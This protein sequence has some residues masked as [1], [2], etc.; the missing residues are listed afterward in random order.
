MVVTT[1]SANTDSFIEKHQKEVYSYQVN[2][3]PAYQ[4]D[5]NARFYED[6]TVDLRHED[7]EY[8]KIVTGD[9]NAPKT[10]LVT[11]ETLSG[12]EYLSI[13]IPL[14]RPPLDDALKLDCRA[15]LEKKKDPEKNGRSLN[16]VTPPPVASNNPNPGDPVLSSISGDSHIEGAT[17][18]DEDWV[19]DGEH[20]GYSA[21]PSYGAPG[22]S[23]IF[24]FM[25]RMVTANKNGLLDKLWGICAEGSPAATSETCSPGDS[26]LIGEFRIKGSS[27]VGFRLTSS[28]CEALFERRKLGIEE[29][30]GSSVLSASSYKWCGAG[31]DLATETCPETGG[32]A[33]Q[34][35]DIEYMCRRHDHA[36]K[37]AVGG[38]GLPRLSCQ[39]DYDIQVGTTIGA[40]CWAGIAACITF[41]PV[42]CAA[43]LAACDAE[44]GV[45]IVYGNNSP[46]GMSQGCYNIEEVAT[47]VYSYSAAH[48]HWCNCGWRGC[49]W[50]CADNHGETYV[51]SHTYS[52]EEVIRFGSDRYNGGNLHNYGYDAP[53][54]DCVHTNSDGSTSA[55]TT[56]CP[57]DSSV[58]TSTNS[59]ITPA[60]VA[61]ADG[62]Y[63]P[64][65]QCAGWKDYY[66]PWHTWVQE[67]CPTTCCGMF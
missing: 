27:V 24:Y 41:F 34:H 31:T 15:V 22:A 50:G 54:S 11:V 67:Q 35:D 38:F 45:G 29:W 36:K 60:C 39:A 20:D 17:I 16:P 56:T 62:P 58:F 32:A 52:T 21:K 46:I 40:T 7:D 30:F 55:C 26:V 61:A 25:N 1:P 43:A 10:N 13:V 4:T 33:T 2:L 18:V 5:Q 57:S 12:A 64:T 65:G 42:G 9:R 53:G 47:P 6:W 44:D 49:S 14:E 37:V 3:N 8:I 63:G 66:C 23:D 51:S 48:N 28:A 59:W 19:D